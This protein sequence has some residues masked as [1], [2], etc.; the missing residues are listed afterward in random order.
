MR[1]LYKWLV[2]MLL[3]PLAQAHLMVAQHGTL[4]IVDDRVFMV[5]S[6]PASAFESIDDD[7]DGMVSMIEFNHHREVIVESVRREVALSEG[8]QKIS[9]RD[10]LLSPVVP[11]DQGGNR[12]LQIVV[13]ARFTLNAVDKAQFHIGLFGQQPEEQAMEITAIHGQS[14]QKTVFVLTP[15]KPVA[16]LFPDGA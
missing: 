15:T 16:V 3:T 2:L 6:L 5:L 11:H 8:L 12:V 4:N 14:N 7:G 1:A 10:I 13:M 9:L